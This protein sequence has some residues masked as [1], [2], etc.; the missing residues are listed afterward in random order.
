MEPRG[1]LETPRGEPPGP[2]GRG[3]EDEALGEE[4]GERW[5]PEFHLQRKLA[6]SSHSEQQDRNRVS[7]ELIM[8]VQEMKKYFPSER[9]NKP[10][11]L[12]AL[13]YALRCVHSVQANGEFFQILS[14]NGAPQADVTM[15]SLE[16][17]ATIASEHTSKN[18]DTF[19]AVFSFLSG[20]LVHA[21]E[22]AALILNRKKDVL[23]SSHFVDLLAPQDVR[24][25]YA[26]TARA[27]LPFWNNW[28]QRAAPRYECAPV[29]PFFCRI[30]GGED[31]KQEKRH[32]PFRIIPYLIYV[33][34]PGQPESES[35][36][37]CLTVVEKIHSGYEAPRIPVNKRIFT[38]TH[39]PGCVFLEVD[40]RA[41][42]LLGYLPQD[43]IGTSILSYLHPE[44]RSLMVAIHQKVLK[45]AGH[46]PFEHSPIR[47]CTQNGDYIILDSS[48]SSFVNPWSRKVSFIIGRHK[49]R[50][51]PLNEDVFATKIKKTNNNDKD[52]TE[53]QEQIYKLLLQP[54]HVS[55]SSGYGSLGSSGS[56]EQLVSIA[57]SSEASGHCVEETKAEQMTLQQVYA[58]VNKI[59]NL[60]QQLYI[61]SMTKSSFRPVTGTCTEL[62][63]GGESANDGGEYKTF[64]SFHQTLK[65]NSVYTEPYEDLRNDEHSPSYQQ[66]NCI[67]SVI[68]YLKSYNIPALKRKCISCTNTTSSSSEEDKQNHKADDVQALQA[69]LQ[70]STIPKSEMPTNG[71]SIDA[72]GGAPQILSTAVLSLGSGISQCGYSSTIV[73]VPPETARDATL[74]CEPWTL[75]M[76]PAPLTSEEFKHVGLTAAVLSAHT[77][78]EEQNYVDKFRE[79]ILSSPY[80]SYLQQ[81]SRSKAK[82]SYFQG[83]YT[84]KQTQLAG[85]RKGK[86]KRKKLP[87]PP[88]SSSSNAG[89]GPHREV[90]Q[91]AQPC[92]PSTASSPHTLG[93]TFPPAAMVPSQSPYLVPAFPLPAATCPGRE[94]AAPGTVPEGLHGPPLSKDLQP[95]PAFPSP[96]LDTFMT[97]FLPDPPVCPLLSPSF[98]PCPFLGATASSAISPSMSAMTPTLDPPASVTNQRREEEKWEA[99]SEGHPFITSRSSSPLQLNLLQE[100]MP[101][102]SESPD[103]MRRNTCP[104]AEYQCVAG[105][106]SSESSPATTGALSMGSPPR[107]N[108]SHPTASTLSMGSPPS[109]TPSYPTASVLSTGSPPCESLSGTGSAASGSSNSSLYFTSSVYSKISQN[110]Q[111]SQDVQKKETFP[112]VAE[113]SIWRMIRQ[114]PECVLMTYQVPERVKEVV[115]KEDLEKLENMR[116][117][118]PQFSHGQKEEL[119]KVYNWIQSQTVPQEINIQVTLTSSNSPAFVLFWRPVSLAKMKIQLMVRPHPAVRLWQKTAAE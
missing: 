48:W 37:C 91:N 76:Q 43:L 33:H 56:Q 22:Q 31:R 49:V 114:T 68:R 42:P 82:Y 36:P 30:R 62:N 90:C 17:L 112:N 104:Q 84:S 19:V 93:P 113:E 40:E 106:S 67:D 18:T 102:R 94:Y 4:S 70:I 47:F 65:N 25:F 3:A 1:D 69:G 10:S 38:T 35:E 117:Q 51:S 57:S 52:V 111:Q 98:F 7:E 83:D 11:T 74:I 60:G 34:R 97:V 96:Y 26:H 29:K 77:Q 53:L 99:Q 75:N 39:T 9:R 21:S 54:V 78:K 13:N 15:Y 80:S 92:C 20:R 63:G 50:T 103:Q 85:C 41:V 46:P 101:R 89:S 116:Q 66:I 95:Y 28:T 105:N 118:Q 73:H 23:A 14:Q 32:S 27:Q 119:A 71:L 55:V 2:G 64:T 108:P 45:Y 8:I 115:L 87:E 88:D 59:K 110:G 107:E 24:V 100:E 61:K 86:H 79:K 58:S 81:E 5:S 109:G 6:E 72:G 12:D 16:E 44:D